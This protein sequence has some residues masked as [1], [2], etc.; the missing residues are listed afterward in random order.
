VTSTTAMWLLRGAMTDK[1]LLPQGKRRE[2][3]DS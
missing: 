3:C 2:R 1:I